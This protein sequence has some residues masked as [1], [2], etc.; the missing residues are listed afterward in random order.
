MRPRALV[1][2]TLVGCS[3]GA[4]GERLPADAGAATVPH[5]SVA[6][7]T[8][9]KA[10]GPDSGPGSRSDEGGIASRGGDAGSCAGF[11]YCED[12]EDFDGP[13]TPGEHLGP[14]TASVWGEPT[15]TGTVDTVRPYTGKKSFH[16]VMPATDQAGRMLT[17][18]TVDGGLVAGNSLFGRAMIY[19]VGT[20]GAGG[21]GL[22]VGTHS[23]IFA[24]EGSSTEVGGHVS[25]NMAG[26]GSLN[27]QPRLGTTFELGNAGGTPTTNAWHCLQWEYDGSSSLP[28]VVA[29]HLRVWLDG[30]IVGD[31]PKSQG[32]HLAT[33]WTSFQIGLTHFQILKNPVEFFLDTFALD[34]AMIPCP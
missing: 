1:A 34:G 23:F 4:A 3:A 21:S 31:V 20:P 27:Y 22:P 14:W 5:S 28:L 9:P 24:V 33:P 12:F 25:V 13:I 26:D 30:Q 6:S 10:D 29:D 7:A 11:A 17:R 32:W 18:P 8:D 2:V 15:A 19:F 16:V